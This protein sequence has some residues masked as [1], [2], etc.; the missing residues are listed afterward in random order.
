MQDMV[1]HNGVESVLGEDDMFKSSDSEETVPRPSIGNRAAHD[2]NSSALS[3]QA[4]NTNGSNALAVPCPS[5]TSALAAQHC[6]PQ[7]PEISTFHSS[8]HATTVDLESSELASM[9]SLPMK[10]TG[11]ASNSA[12]PVSSLAGNSVERPLVEVSADEES[13]AGRSGE[14]KVQSSDG[15]DDVDSHV[16]FDESDSLPL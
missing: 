9:T 1:Q 10:A 15:D 13:I 5:D 2:D 6:P 11:I 4:V 8:Y 16:S 7:H 14:Q 3:S 12:S